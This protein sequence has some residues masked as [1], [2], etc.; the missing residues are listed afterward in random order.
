MRQRLVAITIITLACALVLWPPRAGGGDLRITAIDVGQG[1]AIL[2]QTP[3]RHTLMIDTGGKLE[4]G[5]TPQGASVAEEVGEKI[6][7][8][9]LI[10]QGIHHVDAILLTHPHGD[11]VG[12]IAPILRTLG[13]DILFDGGQKYGGKAYHD[14]LNEARKRHVRIV[15]PRVG[16]VWKTE[17]GVSLHFLT[18]SGTWIYDRRDQVN[19]NSLVVMLECTCGRARPFRALFMGDA[20]HLSEQRLLARHMDVHADVL[21]V[22]HHGSKYAST[23]D[24]LAAVGATDAIISD[25]RH[26]HY[27]DPAPQA[28][29]NLESAHMRV[30]RTDTC[31]AIVVCVRTSVT[32]TPTI[33]GCR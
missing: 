23:P 33:P 2:V 5:K 25:G 30:W 32:I 19:E 16:D 28:L 18:P 22:G 11:H 14:A 12:G 29:D 26:N 1:D 3:H 6:V 4:F 17:D 21:K 7:V 31:G 8:P 27:G 20:G 15:A 10:R 13:A 9:F 24:F